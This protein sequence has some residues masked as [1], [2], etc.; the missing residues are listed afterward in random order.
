MSTRYILLITLFLICFGVSA[1]PPEIIYPGTA[2]KI[3]F[4]DDESYGPFNIGFSFTFYGNL[5]SQFYINSNGMILFG[6]G[7][8]D[9]TEDP[10]PS[11]ALPN[12]FIAPFWDDLVIDTSGKIIY[13]TI[14]SVGNRKLVVQFLNMGF[15]NNPFFMGT[16]Q[17]ILYETSNTIQVQYRQIV[18][19]NSPRAH[20]ASAAIGLENA[21]GTNGI[22]YSYRDETAITDE[23]AISFSTSGSTYTVNSSAIYDGI[24]LTTNSSLPEPGIT[25]LISPPENAAIDTSYIFEWSAAPYATSYKLYISNNS[26]LSASTSYPAGAN[27]TYDITGLKLNATFYWSVFALNAT[28]T[29]WCEIKKFTTSSTAPLAPVAQTIWIEKGKEK[30]IKLTYSGGG[31][32]AKNIIITKLPAQGQLYQYNAGVKGSLISSVPTTLTDPGRNVIY[33]ASGN[34]GNGAGNFNF[35]I[36]DA[37]GDSPEETITINVTSPRVPNLLYIAKN[38]NVE[39]QFDIEMADPAGKQN[40]FKVKANGTP[41]AI[42]SASLKKGDLNTILLT[43]VSPL[44]GTE[45][46][47]VSYTQGDVSGATG[48]YL[49]SFT[50]QPVTLTAQ[51]IDFSQSLSKK[52]SDSPFVLTASSS[53]GLGIGYSSSNPAVATVH[54]NVATF[55]DIGTS[56]ITILQE[57]NAIFAPVRFIKTLTVNKGDQTITFNALPSKTFGDADFIVA[58]TASSGL[59]LSYSIDSISVATLNGNLVHITG[60]GTAVITASQSGDTLWNAAPLVPQI[61]TVNKANQSISYNP[62]PGLKYGD[63]DIDPGA[64]AS[65][66]LKITY[67]SDNPGIASIISG[68][69]H[70]TGA[71]SAVITA[72]QSGN[73]NYNAAPD[74]PHTL[75]VSKVNLTFTADNKSRVYQAQ[76]PVLTFLSSGFVY[77]ESQSVLDVLP[78]I[79]TTAV[80]DSPVGSYPITI[81]GG[82]DKNYNYFYIPGTLTVTKIPQTI[83]FSAVPAR[84]LEKDSYTLVATSTSGLAVLFES[85]NIQKAT[86]KE[87]HLTGVSKGN[88]QIRAYSPGDQYYDAA[89]A[90]ATVEIYSTHRDIMN[91][92][93]PN[94]DGYNDFWELPDLATWGKCDVKVYNR[95]GKLVFS[96]A[97][98]NNL[99]DGTSNGSPLSEG[100]YYFIIKTQ[101]AGTIKG[102]VN[103]VR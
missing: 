74:I 89:E 25:S 21:A 93:T 78:I 57:G 45:T 50:D 55:H 56:D 75:S 68:V 46:V 31:G 99:W 61:L 14:G 17:V 47:L 22:Q 94:N 2:A 41:V 8:S 85:K 15:Y 39:I 30:T 67:S 73:K 63:T 64:T 26:D 3:G 76:N 6:T 44:T 84:L 60:A 43:M 42:G 83:T 29:S 71:G 66:G 7:S 82:N 98:Y 19:P 100:A 88:V 32:S 54:N 90:I 87:N 9:E 86:V 37:G 34:T 58:V 11:A 80:Q 18:D 40:Q 72:S 4:A 49:A 51:T 1:Q 13:K 77:G 69:I 91:L 95:W 38:V 20:G 102:T 35:R 12:N 103:I 36:N 27:L 96:D 16:F 65:S 92:F 52:F 53:S 24:Y 33:V 62:L 48:G 5:Y 23:Q 81:T 59:V 101:N 79:R 70:I 28:G 97:N 10:I